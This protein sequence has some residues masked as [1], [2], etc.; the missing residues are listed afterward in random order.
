[1]N[2]VWK[3]RTQIFY[4]S[5]KNSFRYWERQSNFKVY[6]NYKIDAKGLFAS[7]HL[8]KHVSEWKRGIIQKFPDKN[9]IFVGVHCRRTDFHKHYK[10][11][12]N[13]TLVGQS[14]FNTAFEI[15]RY[16]PVLNVLILKILSYLEKNTTMMKIRLCS[17]LSVT[18]ISGSR[19]W[20][21]ILF[22]LTM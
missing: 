3:G 1:M 5:T 20:N 9:I 6:K 4:G 19:Y 18:I 11:V 10:E 8:K 22:F 17:W 21:I 2:Q 7:D 15:Y 14:Y 12:S 13:S 16:A